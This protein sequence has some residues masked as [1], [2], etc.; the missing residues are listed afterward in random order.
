MLETIQIGDIII[1]QK[2]K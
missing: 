2:I 1:M